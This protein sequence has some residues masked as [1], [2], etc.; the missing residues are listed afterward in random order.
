MRKRAI[1]IIEVIVSMSLVA[2]CFALTY[3]LFGYA[4]RKTQNQE[5]KIEHTLEHATLYCALVDTLGQAEVMD[6]SFHK[7][8]SEP[9][10]IG[11]M[12]KNFADLDP[13]LCGLV[14]AAIALN[15]KTSQ[16]ELR[17]FKCGTNPN[18]EMPSKKVVLLRNVESWSI[19][20]LDLKRSLQ[21][22]PRS[23]LMIRKPPQA[24]RIRLTAK[25]E[26]FCF[27]INFVNDLALNL[28]Q[29]ETL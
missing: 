4:K 6:Q 13:D 19:E 15:T 7:L 23:A 25:K 2:G 8:F 5:K 10:G 9:S 21:W 28:T 26:E 12:Y 18:C 11:F 24:L 1:S 27:V 3:Q 14:Y 17:L 16:L 22:Q 20:E 29:T